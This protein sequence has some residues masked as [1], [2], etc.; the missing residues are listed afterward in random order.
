MTRHPLFAISLCLALPVAAHPGLEPHGVVH[1]LLHVAETN[2]P[3]IA[4]IVV[5]AALGVTAGRRARAGR[6]RNS[7]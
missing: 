3:A 1:Q 7:D 2:L 6:G 5:V 4:L